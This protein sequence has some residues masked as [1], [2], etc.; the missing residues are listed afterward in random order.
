MSNLTLPSSAISLRNDCSKKYL[1]KMMSASFVFI[2]VFVTW[3]AG[4]PVNNEDTNKERNF[5]R[6]FKEIKLKRSPFVG[7]PVDRPRVSLDLPVDWSDF[8][9]GGLTKA[10]LGAVFQRLPVSGFKGLNNGGLVDALKIS[11]AIGAVGT[12]SSLSDGGLGESLKRLP[13][14]G[15]EISPVNQ[16]VETLENLSEGGLGETFENLSEVGLVE[17]LENLSEGGLV[18]TLENLSE[19]GLVEKIENL[20]EGGLG[21]TLENISEGELVDKIEN[22]SEGG[23]GETLENLSEGGLVETN[24]NLSE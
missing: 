4:M 7:L 10:G 12:L 13:A 8:R 17:T 18:E 5:T 16:I 11:P 24:E 3:S 2:L 23:L 15:L 22:L 9:R 20:S 1:E 6:R 14:V 19:G 21:E